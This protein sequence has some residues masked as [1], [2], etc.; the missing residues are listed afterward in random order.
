MG[1]GSHRASPLH[2]SLLPAS[3]CICKTQNKMLSL[4]RCKALSRCSLWLALAGFTHSFHC[5]MLKTLM[6][7]KTAMQP[8]GS[9]NF[10]MIERENVAKGLNLSFL[11]VAW[12]G[13][14]VFSCQSKHFIHPLTERAVPS[15]PLP[16]PWARK[17]QPWVPSLSLCALSCAPKLCPSSWEMGAVL[18]CLLGTQGALA[19]RAAWFYRTITEH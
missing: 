3:S 8:N 10:V 11:L 1:F 18:S 16:L 19:L 13:R 9:A 12:L 4:R 2:P 17:G 5:V 15:A 7:K 6:L 14:A